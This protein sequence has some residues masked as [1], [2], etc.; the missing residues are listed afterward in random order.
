MSSKEKKFK[1]LGTEQLIKNNLIIVMSV[2]VV[3]GIINLISKQFF[4]AFF[5]I[6]IALLVIILQVTLKKR[7]PQDARIFIIVNAQF[8]IIF[9]VSVFKGTVHEMFALYLASCV[10]AGVYFKRKIVVQLGILMNVCLLGAL[11]FAEF[12]YR[13]ATT[14]ALLKDFL[15]L[16]LGTIF[17]WLVVTW[18][19]GF[20]EKAQE[21]AALS[22]NLV[23]DVQEKIKEAELFNVQQEQL[24]ANVL[25]SATTVNSISDKMTN[26]V[27]ELHQGTESQT[28]AVDLMDS[29]V[30]E[31]RC[32]IENSSEVCHKSR[33]ATVTVSEQLFTGNQ[34]MKQLVESMNE[35]DHT[36]SEISKVLKTIDNIAFQTNILALNASVEAARA[37][38]AGKGFSV[39]AEEVRRLAAQSAVAASNTASLMERIN[40]V[41]QNTISITNS[42]AKAITTVMSS[43]E[44]SGKGIDDIL[45]LATKQIEYVAALADDMENIT[46]VVRQNTLMAEQSTSISN[47]LVIQAQTLHS[48]VS[49]G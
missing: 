28:K 25:H 24:F 30:R 34:Q 37:G 15:A 13:G 39:V 4:A 11:P 21:S 33:N 7:I 9:L 5:I 46:A 6:G 35:I 2:C 18:G 42:T 44:I 22:D 12:T 40:E 19:N 26:V 10:M 1:Q 16:E 43:A 47:E 45:V 17:V 32:E 14:S 38:S 27:T 3:F 20:I 31:L 36:V 41:T 48:L 8:L 23:L 29:A 49:A